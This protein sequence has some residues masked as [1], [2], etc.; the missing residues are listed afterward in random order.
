[1]NTKDLIKQKALEL[2]NKKG[3]L[4][5]TL[6]DVAA[7]LDKSYGN[8]TYHYKTKE[9]VIEELYADMVAE[10]KIISG[11][12]LAAGD[13]FGS[14]IT[15][16]AYTFDLSVKY[17][18]LFKDFIE[19][20][21]TYPKI[22]KKVDESNA[23]RKTQLKQALVILQHQELLRDDL[24]D[25]D[26][27]YLMELSGAIRTFFFLN[28]SISDLKKKDLKQSYIKYVNKLIEPYLSVEGRGKY[29]NMIL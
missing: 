6:R 21:R 27:N 5:I 22:A 16:P 3:M 14:I 29:D 4:N 2:F 7:E 11:Q 1:M 8:I 13:I 23:L 26:L 20:K 17:L 9:S 12:I 19:I 15:A 24:N 18:F 25:E 28:L 10:L